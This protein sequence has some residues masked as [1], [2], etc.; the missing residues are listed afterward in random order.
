MIGRS[1]TALGAFYRRLSSR[2][3]KQK[4]VTATA[5]KIAVR[6]HNTLRFGRSYHDPGAAAYEER[7]PTRVLANLQRRAKTLGY[8]LAPVPDLDAVSWKATQFFANQK[9]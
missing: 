9:P 8:I 3:G 1:E 4:A 2:I 5:R 6:F 7:Y